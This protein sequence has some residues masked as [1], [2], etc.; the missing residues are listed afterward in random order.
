MEESRTR[1]ADCNGYLWGTLTPVYEKLRGVS[2]VY[3]DIYKSRVEKEVPFHNWS[4]LHNPHISDAAKAALMREWDEDS[5]E[6][7]IHGMF[8]PM[9]IQ[10]AFNMRLLREIGKTVERNPMI[11]HIR[12]N[13]EGKPELVAA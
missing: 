9:G 10:L 5:R 8:V 1:V 13:E 4:L 2:W 11:G 12:F 6:V 3:E 7:R